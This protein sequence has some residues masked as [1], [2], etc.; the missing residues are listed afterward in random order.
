MSSSSTTSTISAS[1]PPEIFGEIV[2]HVAELCRNERR[3]FIT[4][5]E[6]M[7]RLATVSQIFLYFARTHL[8]WHV[9]I[10]CNRMSKRKHLENLANLLRIR[11]DNPSGSQVGEMVQS[12]TVI[13]NADI[14]HNGEL[15]PFL[16][17]PNVKW[18]T[19]L[20]EDP[21]IRDT[22]P[23]AYSPNPV[24]TLGVRTML[25]AY[26]QSGSLR[27][28]RL[29]NFKS[30]PF[31]EILSSPVLESLSLLRCLTGSPF[32]G[33]GN[34]GNET[35]NLSH[36]IRSITI[37]TSSVPLALLMRC[38]KIER[39][40]LSNVT[41]QSATPD[42]K[43]PRQEGLFPHL[44]DV[45]FALTGHSYGTQHEK[46][47]L[48]TIFDNSASPNLTSA[49]IY[50]PSLY[51]RPAISVHHGL[52]RLSLTWRG[53][54]TPPGDEI[55][56]SAIHTLSRI[57]GTSLQELILLIGITAHFGDADEEGVF[58]DDLYG[59]THTITTMFQP[60]DEDVIFVRL[61]S[62][63]SVSLSLEVHVRGKVS[64]NW[65]DPQCY[66]GLPITVPQQKR[67]VNFTC[68]VTV[69]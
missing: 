37:K 28:L 54:V 24:T 17:L 41:I 63:Q 67:R 68:K 44:K 61:P 11:T 9:T 16:A 1:F 27:N 57:R 4:I 47:L 26:L 56:A 36:S 65:A 62:L 59:G 51:R 60:E 19:I 21:S 53:Y 35:M 34:S 43:S 66:L 14:H 50:M 49:W 38:K 45:E 52:Q 30:V 33:H 2:G 42:L 8:F 6:E 25:G 32:R 64:S 40:I 18:M 12:I 3:G 48:D 46:L 5:K 20:T 29:E 31:Q 13:F 15:S 23:A 39:L 58:I 7:K 55:V 69:D 22:E 10:P